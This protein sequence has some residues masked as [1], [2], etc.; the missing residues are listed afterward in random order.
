MTVPSRDTLLT[1]SYH[2]AGEFAKPLANP[3]LTGGS[4]G[5]RGGNVPYITG[6][7]HNWLIKDSVLSIDPTEGGIFISCALQVGAPKAGPFQGC[8]PQISAAEVGL[9]EGGPP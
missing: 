3:P 1:P 4:T 9:V 6:M 2:T 5:W 7:V 8:P